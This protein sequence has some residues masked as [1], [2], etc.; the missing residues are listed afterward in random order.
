LV[1]DRQVADLPGRFFLGGP[2]QDQ[3]QATLEV[4]HV[5]LVQV[6]VCQE[7]DFI[8]AQR[9]AGRISCRRRPC[10]PRA[11]TSRLPAIASRRNLPVS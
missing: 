9:S 11:V 4:S 8:F 7:D 1:L 6:P 3:Q 2:H 5:A 10:V